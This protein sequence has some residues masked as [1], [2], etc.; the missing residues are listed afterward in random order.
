[1][2]SALLFNTGPVKRFPLK[3]LLIDAKCTD[4]QFIKCTDKQTLAAIQV[5]RQTSKAN[6]AIQLQN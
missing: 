4:K 1:M 6:Q 2:L 3:Q 5:H